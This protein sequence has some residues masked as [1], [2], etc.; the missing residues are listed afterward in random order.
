MSP[1]TSTSLDKENEWPFSC[2]FS[3][4][5]SKVRTNNTKTSKINGHFVGF[6]LLVQKIGHSKKQ[7]TPNTS[8][9]KEIQ[10]EWSCYGFSSTGSKVRTF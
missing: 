4:S 9:L 1:N 3:T 2:G 8:T 7:V 10:N 5:G 6:Y